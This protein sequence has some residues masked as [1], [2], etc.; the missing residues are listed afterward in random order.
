MEKHR[1]DVPPWI[2]SDT[3]PAIFPAM[4]RIVKEIESIRKEGKNKEQGYVFR[5]IDQVYNMIHS[6]LAAEGV[7]TPPRV[8]NKEISTRQTAKGSTMTHVSMDVEFWFTAPDGSAMCVGPISSEALD[9]SDKAHNKALSFAQK[10]AIVQTFTIPTID[11]QEG[12]RDNLGAIPREP[13]QRGTDAS[14]PGPQGDTR[15]TVPP[16]RPQ[17]RPGEGLPE[18][19]PDKIATIPTA[20]LVAYRQLAGFDGIPLETLTQDDRDL[21]IE[22]L[23]RAY[24][25]RSKKGGGTSQHGLAWI[26]AIISECMAASVGPPSKEQTAG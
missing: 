17:R 6:L 23:K 2:P 10:Y 9:T 8:I 3:V 4:G 1:Y 21:V 26:R 14:P 11:V 13:D 12:D 5:G 15:G 18:I 20:I 24:D 25:A 22:T 19:I 16:V 7:T